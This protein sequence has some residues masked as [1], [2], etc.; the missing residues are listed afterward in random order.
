[1]ADSGPELGQIP[2]GD[3][4]VFPVETDCIKQRVEEV[5]LWVDSV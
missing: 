5:L 3:S 4:H 2:A 1:M